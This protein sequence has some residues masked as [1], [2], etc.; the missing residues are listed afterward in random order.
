MYDVFLI[1]SFLSFGWVSFTIGQSQEAAKH[2]DREQHELCH[3][4][5][6][7]EAYIAKRGDFYRCFM[8][9]RDYPHRVKASHLEMEENAP[10]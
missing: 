7:H 2:L 8:E 6:T 5:K 1:V 9:H 3:D 10:E 4:S